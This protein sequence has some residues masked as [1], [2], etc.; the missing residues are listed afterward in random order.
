[1]LGFKI[2][3]NFDSLCRKKIHRLFFIP[4]NVQGRIVLAG[5]CLDNPSGKNY[6]TDAAAFESNICRRHA[7]RNALRI[8]SPISAARRSS[9]SIAG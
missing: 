8:D 3:I 7:H 4:M 5:P 1:M 2:T 6:Q 9:E